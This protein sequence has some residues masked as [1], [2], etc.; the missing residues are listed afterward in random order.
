M[1]VKAKL[2]KKPNWRSASAIWIDRTHGEP[3]FDLKKVST[4]LFVLDV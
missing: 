2:N 4:K 3:G 1:V